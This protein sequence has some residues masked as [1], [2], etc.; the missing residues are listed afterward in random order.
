MNIF[1]L[2]KNP[3][4]CA[5]YHCDKH[6]YNQTT[7]IARLL[8]TV[9][10]QKSVRDE[11]L[12]DTMLSGDSDNNGDVKFINWA[13]NANNFEWTLK[14]GMALSTEYSCRFNQVHTAQKVLERV[15]LV[16]N[17]VKDGY[18]S[19]L[20]KLH[21]KIRLAN[22]YSVI[23]GH[24]YNAIKSYRN[25]YIMN[26]KNLS[27]YTNCDKPEW[28]DYDPYPL[29][30][31]YTE[32]PLN[33]FLR[34]GEETAR[35]GGSHTLSPRVRD[36]VREVTRE[37]RQVATM[38]ID[39]RVNELIEGVRPTYNSMVD[40]DAVRPIMSGRQSRYFDSINCCYTPSESL[41]GLTEYNSNE[42]TMIRDSRIRLDELLSAYNSNERS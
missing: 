30:D 8:S 14:L 39:P 20:V 33:E 31:V 7:E 5:K 37:P 16:F 27:S 13:S 18:F 26:K 9:L 1:V 19:S 6:V 23:N 32:T 29:Q 10:Y 25:Y 42:P 22:K 15:Y 41:L 4:I 40:V 35:R 24:D 12:Y 21:F 11:L 28:L 38:I 3:E 36:V 17:S 2:D 34:L